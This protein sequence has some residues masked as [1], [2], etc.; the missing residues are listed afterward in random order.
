MAAK[1]LAVL[2]LAVIAAACGSRTAVDVFL[3]EDAGAPEAPG[4]PSLGDAGPVIDGSVTP[5]NDASSPWSGGCGLEAGTYP[6]VLTPL[7][8]SG[9]CAQLA[10]QLTL[11]VDGV[12]DDGGFPDGCACTGD[13]LGCDFVSW[14]GEDSTVTQESINY[15]A[16]GFSGMLTTSIHTLDGSVVESCEWAIGGGK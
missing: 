12:M 2:G 1:A 8:D 10:S 5:D 11:G 15:W 6:V 14:S 7:L 9:D 13:F 16:G 4:T 3:I